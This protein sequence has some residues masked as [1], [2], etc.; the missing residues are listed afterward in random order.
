[1]ILSFA[2]KPCCSNV[3]CRTFIA[4]FFDSELEESFKISLYSILSFMLLMT[5]VVN[6]AVCSQFRKSSLSVATR[7]TEPEVPTG[8]LRSD[9]AYM[10]RRPIIKRASRIR[11]SK[12]RR[13]R[14]ISQH[15]LQVLC[16]NYIFESKHFVKKMSNNQKNIKLFNDNN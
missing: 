12:V 16:L 3:P 10:A 11:R 7:R 6:I 9:Y 5:I 15:R 2:N 4:N 14:R 8:L 13:R 1:M